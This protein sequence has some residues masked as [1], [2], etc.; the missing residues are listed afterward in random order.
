MTTPVARA[1]TAERYARIIADDDIDAFVP[2]S[3]WQGAVD[4]LVGHV[5][6][7]RVA[8]GFIA[9]IETC[10]AVLAEH[11]PNADGNPNELP[12]RIYFI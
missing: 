4:A 9:A 1:R 12:D 10:G 2:Q 11:F 8:D 6:E 7:G 3:F 5:R